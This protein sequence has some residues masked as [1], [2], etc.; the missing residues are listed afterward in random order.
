MC[1][2]EAE[3]RVQNNLSFQLK[4]D[5]LR[6]PLSPHSVCSDR[7]AL[8]VTP[9][10]ARRFVLERGVSPWCPERVSGVLRVGD[11]VS[12]ASAETPLILMMSTNG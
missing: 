6:P 12:F 1:C 7:G 9:R 2:C 3:S 11:E 4:T 8:V 10:V 5:V